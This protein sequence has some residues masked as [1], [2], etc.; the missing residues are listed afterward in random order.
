MLIIL[1]HKKK[2]LNGINLFV[3]FKAFPVVR[4]M[5]SRVCDNRSM[6]KKKRVCSVVKLF[7]MCCEGFMPTDSSSRSDVLLLVHPSQSGQISCK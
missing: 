3:V 7:S 5:C 6:Q 1:H 2:L 4:E